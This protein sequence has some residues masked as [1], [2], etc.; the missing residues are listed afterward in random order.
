MQAVLPFLRTAHQHVDQRYFM[1]P[2]HHT[3]I[4]CFAYGALGVEATERGMDETQQLAALLVILQTLSELSAP[5][6]SGMLGRCMTALDEDEGYGFALT[7]ARTYNDW[8]QTDSTATR[9]LAEK[10][11]ELR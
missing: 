4:Y 9:I 3:L 7:G 5:D 6:I 8:R 1:T 10:L 11:Q 2:R